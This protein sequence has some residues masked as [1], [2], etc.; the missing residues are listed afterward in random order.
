[1]Q[2]GS[3]WGAYL[4]EY[5]E[6]IQNPANSPAQLSVSPRDMQKHAQFISFVLPKAGKAQEVILKV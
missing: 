4:I 2:S 3:F 6:D 1:M 5:A